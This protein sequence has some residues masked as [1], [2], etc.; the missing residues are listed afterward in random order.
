MLLGEK[1]QSP[2]L[3]GLSQPRGYCGLTSAETPAVGFSRP[4]DKTALWGL[5]L[6]IFD[7]PQKGQPRLLLATHDK[8][9]DNS[10]TGKVK[11]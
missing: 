3:Q 8:V 11:P 4:K 2:Q 6:L 9:I 10:L 5:C 7:S 1:K